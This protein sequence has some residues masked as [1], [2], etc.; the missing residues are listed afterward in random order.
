MKDLRRF[1]IIGGGISGSILAYRLIKAGLTVTVF[2]DSH[3]NSASRVAAGVWHPLTFKRLGHAWKAKEFTKVLLEFYQQLSKEVQTES[4]HYLPYQRVLA[5]NVSVNDWQAK[6][7]EEDSLF[8]SHEEVLENAFNAPFGIGNALNSGFV[9]VPALIHDVKNW[10]KNQPNGEVVE[11]HLKQNNLEVTSDSVLVKVD[12]QTLQ[13]NDLIYA[14][15]LGVLDFPDFNWLPF[16]PVKGE[17]LTIRAEEVPEEAIRSKQVFVVPLGNQLFKVGANYSHAE[18][19]A[20]PTNKAREELENKLQEFLKVHYEVIDH[21]A[22]IRPAVKG[23]KPMIGAH[24]EKQNIW[25]FNGMGSKAV[26]MVPLLS[27]QLLEY[28]TVGTPL[29]A[30]VDVARFYSYFRQNQKH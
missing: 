16:Q 19:N 30:E 6:S 5:D 29:W 7:T 10:I 9:D 26:L 1:G 4:I 12:G 14:N 3:P 22:G 18:L 15:G 24:P 23:R 20:V 28:I 27:Q 8:G 11:N 21:K 25:L 13:F 2:D 17:V